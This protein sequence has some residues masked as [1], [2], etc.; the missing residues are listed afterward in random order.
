[1]ID[2]AADYEFVTGITNDEIIIDGDILPV[3]ESYEEP[4]G[5]QKPR[6]LRG[7]DVAFLMEAANERNSVI[8][9]SA[10]VTAFDREVSDAQ[11]ATI[12]TNLHR[13][14]RTGNANE[15]C[16]I[17]QGF[18]FADKWIDVPESLDEFVYYEDKEDIAPAR[19]Y[20][21]CVM[22][23]KSASPSDFQPNG[24]LYLTNLKKMFEDVA[25]QRR[26][27]CGEQNLWVNEDGTQESADP[28]GVTSSFDRTMNFYGPGQSPTAPIYNPYDNTGVLFYNTNDN[29]YGGVYETHT[30][31]SYQ[32]QLPISAFSASLLSEVTVLAVCY[33]RSWWHL[34]T[35][36]FVIEKRM[37]VIPLTA[38]MSNGA[39]IL[40][41]SEADKVVDKM[42]AKM[43]RPIR[44]SSIWV[45]SINYLHY[46]FVGL[47]GA[48]PI[49]T[50]GDHTNF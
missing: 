33:G 31:N 44:G 12:C 5:I 36:G 20:G 37:G 9:G 24:S 15:P 13:H 48:T 46:A 47:L 14:V 50:L 28:V 23:D 29:L 1:M 41:K 7:E 25:R 34:G 16:Y 38:T 27:Y 2:N 35:G 39:W 17:K 10:E 49:V 21:E 22:L 30:L 6:C 32:L 43:S 8:A 4:E 11:L 18:Q 45:S 26:I 19:L 40:T 42:A 3:R